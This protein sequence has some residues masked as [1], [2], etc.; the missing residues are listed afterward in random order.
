MLDFPDGLCD[1]NELKC[2][3]V[4]YIISLWSS[5]RKLCWNRFV[6]CNIVFP[7]RKMLVWRT[8]KGE[9]HNALIEY[10]IC[11]L[12]ADL[13]V[14][15]QITQAAYT[16]TYISSAPPHNGPRNVPWKR[17]QTF[18]FP[19]CIVAIIREFLPHILWIKSQKVVRDCASFAMSW[20]CEQLRRVPVVKNCK[21]VKSSV[22]F[23][24]CLE[25]S[26]HQELMGKSRHV[27][28]RMWTVQA[29]L[30]EKI[31]KHVNWVFI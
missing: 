18:P 12:R 30:G 15:F 27:W 16:C 19:T 3:M 5:T 13:Q 28:I 6:L 14:S 10:L 26:M 23:V 9:W 1:N 4:F 24:D 29:Q 31:L 25:Y 2:C 11:L 7:I 17:S 21:T 8:S 20:G 22:T